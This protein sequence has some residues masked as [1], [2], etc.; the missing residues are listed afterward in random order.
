[1]SESGDCVDKQM[2]ETATSGPN[3][4][5]FMLANG[6]GV[7]GRDSETQTRRHM[8]PTVSPSAAATDSIR[9]E[10]N[11]FTGIWIGCLCVS[12]RVGTETW[13]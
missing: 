12:R 7:E 6:D 1:M 11:N 4:C 5:P 13:V 9:P 8:S 10:G 3:S 2:L